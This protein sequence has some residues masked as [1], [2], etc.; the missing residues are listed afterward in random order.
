MLCILE[1]SCNFFEKFVSDE[2]TLAS[3]PWSF[4]K[5]YIFY[6]YKRAINWK[7]K[8]DLLTICLFENKWHESVRTFLSLNLSEFTIHNFYPIYKR[9]DLRRKFQPHILYNIAWFFVIF[10]K[11][12]L[13]LPCCITTDWKSRK[14]F[15]ITQQNLH[16]DGGRY[17]WW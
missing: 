5:L 8:E 10:L 9:Y 1:F 16:A 15:G 12:H 17:K 6:L 14:L 7:L 2:Y 3:H 13:T 11:S 4:A